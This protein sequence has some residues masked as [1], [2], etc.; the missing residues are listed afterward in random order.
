VFAVGRD[1]HWGTRLLTVRDP[2]DRELVV[3]VGE[4]D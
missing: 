2:D 3:Q 1:S 4:A